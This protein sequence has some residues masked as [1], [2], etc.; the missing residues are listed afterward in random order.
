[1]LDNHARAL[2]RPFYFG[3]RDAQ[4][5]PIARVEHKE[6]TTPLPSSGALSLLAKASNVI[7]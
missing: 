7:R 3:P 6:R 2:R 4:R 1:M 5:Y